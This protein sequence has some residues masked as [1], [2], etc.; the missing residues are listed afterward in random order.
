MPDDRTFCFREMRRPLLAR[1]PLPQRGQSRIPSG[2]SIAIQQHLH[3]SE[4]GRIT[5]GHALHKS[6]PVAFR[7][8]QCGLKQPLC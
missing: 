8:G 4:E 5:G 6:S 2:L 1:I 7:M 3:L